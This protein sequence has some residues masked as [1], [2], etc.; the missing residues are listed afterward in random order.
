MQ[1]ALSPLNIVQL[2]ALE[3]S[4][5]GESFSALYSTIPVAL[6][7]AMV[8]SKLFQIRNSLG[9]EEI[10]TMFCFFRFRRR[11]QCQ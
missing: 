4:W 5:P 11:P 1:L 8:W 2:P 10:L 9:D 7:Y 3:L 6:R